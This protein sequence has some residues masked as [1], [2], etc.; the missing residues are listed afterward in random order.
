M[1][2]TGILVALVMLCGCLFSGGSALAEERSQAID[3]AN[4]NV[5]S[6]TATEG[7]DRIT[8]NGNDAG[9]GYKI[10]MDANAQ[11]DVEFSLEI[12]QGDNWA[13]IGFMLAPQ[14][15]HV[16][17]AEQK[18]ISVMLR[19]ASGVLRADVYI[20]L[21]GGRYDPEK[22][23]FT[24]NAVVGQKNT[25]S[26]RRAGGEYSLYMN[27]RQIVTNSGENPVKL[28]FSNSDFLTAEGM[29]Y[30]CF[31]QYRGCTLSVYDIS[32]RPAPADESNWSSADG[33]GF[34]N[35]E[36]GLRVTADAI[37]GYDLDA[38]HIALKL[39]EIALAEGDVA[40][41]LGA[42]K[43]F[44]RVPGVLL[45]LSETDGK[46]M[47]SVKKAGASEENF[48]LGVPLSELSELG[49]RNFG[50]CY[51]VEANGISAGFAQV[52]MQDF[53]KNGT[54]YL[55]VSLA[56]GSA[57]TI[58]SLDSSTGD[59]GKG[60][61]LDPRNWSN[62]KESVEERESSI[63]FKKSTSLNTSLYA[64]YARYSIKFYNLET[65]KAYISL[66]ATAALPGTSG[67][68]RGMM[69]E[70]VDLNGRLYV[71]GYRTAVRNATPIFSSFD[72]GNTADGA[73]VTFKAKSKTG[74]VLEINGRRVTAGGEDVF[75]RY[76]MTELAS[77]AGKFFLG[78]GLDGETT[79][80]LF[81]AD[82]QSFDPAPEVTIP[83][84]V[85]PEGA[86]GMNPEEWLEEEEGSIL[87]NEGGT[88]DMYKSAMLTTPLDSNYVGLRMEL[89]T[90]SDTEA[91]DAWLTFALCSNAD[92]ADTA[93]PDGNLKVNANTLLFMFKN[94]GGMLQMGI[95][96]RYDGAFNAIQGLSTF[97]SG[98]AGT[99]TFELV[100]F[101]SELM[102]YVN[103]EPYTDAS[104]GNPLAN[105]G[106]ANFADKE[107]NTYLGFCSFSAETSYT[108]RNARRWTVLGIDNEMP[109]YFAEQIKKQDYVPV[110]GFEEETP[111][112]SWRTVCLI[113]AG[114]SLAA[115]L[116]AGAGAFL[117]VR[118]RKSK[119]GEQ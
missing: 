44:G 94:T 74:M 36:K 72:A 54:T 85:V 90:L 57:V 6:G 45:A 75:D 106:K 68:A 41:G 50:D 103:G 114:A 28:F 87:V 108:G 38:N 116:A 11:V 16:G 29:T 53:S 10:P 61:A 77:A 101:D 70:F 83:N 81:S 111:D 71:N 47:L 30:A 99:Y 3:R 105:L 43:T 104:G 67:G 78:V 109:A 39:S 79:A 33:T 13:C 65:G 113:A 112:E 8:L 2:K 25:L 93:S 97:R 98:V 82:S 22:T 24:T 34:G 26:L 32:F 100:Y 48:A 17:Q 23:T 119:G 51:R 7:A 62:W 118:R 88:L 56:G 76:A 59:L 102:L 66:F 1:K 64:N 58:E 80:E 110:G 19:N 96:Y 15:A 95:F 27:N 49:F 46:A 12:E 52:L 84:E 21:G 40:F 69:L 35:T 107:G 4:Y 92:S 37:C 117:F 20:C 42:E 9:M 89:Q 91:Q 115:G 73:K 18:G 55:S 63:L 86:L 60:E 14:S 5:T 31:G